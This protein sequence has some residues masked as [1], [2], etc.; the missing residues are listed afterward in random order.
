VLLVDDDQDVLRSTQ[1]GLAFQHQVTAI[2]DAR[3]ALRAI[4]GGERF[5]IILCDLVMP[6]LGGIELHAQ[7][8]EVAPDVLPAIVFVTGGAFTPAAQAF[9]D[10]VRSLEKPVTLAT[11]R[12]LIAAA[13]QIAR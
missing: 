4:V 12:K 2:D 1:R 10:R 13:P 3:H 8:A 6:D 9:L 11:I 5:D 7:L